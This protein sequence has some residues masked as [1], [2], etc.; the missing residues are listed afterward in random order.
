MQYMHHEN[1]TD[2]VTDRNI[3]K[4]DRAKVFLKSAADVTANFEVLGV[5]H[6]I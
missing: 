2:T 4:F 5:S 6:D 3:N 1:K